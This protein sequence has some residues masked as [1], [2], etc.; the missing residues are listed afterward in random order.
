MSTYKRYA[1]DRFAG[2]TGSSG[3]L[4][5]DV[6]DGAIL[7]TTGDAANEQNLFVKV[8]GA[9]KQIVQTGVVLESMTGHLVDSQLDQTISGEKTFVSPATFSGDTTFHDLVTINNLTVTGTQTILNT[10]DSTIKDNLIIIN[11]GESGAGITLQSGGIQ[12]DR[13]SKPDANILFDETLVGN[14]PIAS[15]GG[16]TGGFNFDF[17]VHVTGDRLVRASETGIFQTDLEPV[18]ENGTTTGVVSQI[19]LT[20]VTGVHQ[21]EGISYPADRNNWY[22]RSKAVQ[23]TLGGVLQ[24]PDKYVLSNGG[25][26]ENDTYDQP[27]PLLSLRNSETIF[28]GV[29]YSIVYQVTSGRAS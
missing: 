14:S 29:N 13:G 2:P 21:I 18:F 8:T 16:Y 25:S 19:T 6:A 17:Q 3:V 20:G 9:W 7:I 10:V 1:G 5:Y 27:P 4:P 15:T 28:S 26:E 23:F 12:I 24:T 22:K 11:S